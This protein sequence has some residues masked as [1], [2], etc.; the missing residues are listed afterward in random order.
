MLRPHLRPSTR[1]LWPILPRLS[2][3]FPPH[4][5]RPSLFLRPNP[6]ISPSLYLSLLLTKTGAG[7]GLVRRHPQLTKTSL[8][9]CRCPLATVKKPPYAALMSHLQGQEPPACNSC[10]LG[11]S[12]LQRQPVLVSTGT[13]GSADSRRVNQGDI[14]KTSPFPAISPHYSV[15]MESVSPLVRRFLFCLLFFLVFFT[16]L[17]VCR[18]EEGVED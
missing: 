17:F 8:R 15:S 12:K 9:I 13:S 6:I 3:G 4:R 1:P 10:R 5:Y 11:A 7:L 2:G 14:N 18:A 16:L